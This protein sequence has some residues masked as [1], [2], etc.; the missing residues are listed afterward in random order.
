MNYTAAVAE[1]EAVLSSHQPKMVGFEMD[2]WKTELDAMATNVRSLFFLAEYKTF[3]H[4]AKRQFGKMHD[5]GVVNVDD[6][7]I[8][9]RCKA[10]TFCI[11][12]D[13]MH[14]GHL[15]NNTPFRYPPKDNNT[16]NTNRFRTQAYGR[17]Q[18]ASNVQGVRRCFLDEGTKE[19]GFVN[20]KG[21][22]HTSF[23]E[24]VISECL[25]E[26]HSLSSLAIGNVSA[27]KAHMLGTTILSEYIS[28]VLLKQ[29]RGCVMLLKG[30]FRAI[31]RTEVCTGVIYPNKVVSKPD[32]RLSISKEA[33]GAF[34]KSQ[35]YRVEGK[36]EGRKQNRNKSK[37]SSRDKEVN[38]AARDSNDT[39]VCC[40]ENTVEDCIMD[41]DASFHA[42]YCKEK[43]E[44]FKL[45]SGK[46]RLAVDKTLDIAG[47]GDVLKTSFD[48]SWTLKDV[49]LVVAR[50]N[51]RRS[52]YMVEVH[53]EGIGAIIDGSG[54]AALWF[55][56]AKESFPHN[57]KEDKET[58][59]VEARLAV[60]IMQT[61]RT[62]MLKMVP[63]TPL[64]FGVAK[65][66]S[67]TFR[68]E[69]MGLHSEAPKMLWADS[70]STT[71]LIYRIP[72][73]PIGLC[74]PEEEC[75]SDE[76]KY[77]FRDMKSHQ[78][79]QKSQVV[80]VD[81]PENLA[82][83]DSI[84]AEH[85]LSSKI[86][87]S[88]GGSSN[89]SEG[90]KNSRSFEDSGRLDEEYSKDGASSKEG[91]S[92]TPQIRISSR[93]SRAPVR[94]SPSA[95]YLLLTKNEPD[96][97]LSQITSKKEGITKIVDIQEPSYVGALNDTSTQHKSEG[98]QLAG[99]KE[100]LE[101]RLKEILYEL[102]QAL[103]LQYLKFN[104]FM[105]RIR[106]LIY[107]EDSW[108]EE[109]YRDVHQVG[110]EREVKVLRIFKWP[111]SELIMEDGVLPERGA[112][113][114][115]EVCTEV[116]TGVRY[117][118]I[119]DRFPP[120]PRNLL[121]V[122]TYE[123]DEDMIKELAE[124]YIDHIEREKRIQWKPR[125]DIMSS[126]EEGEETLDEFKRGPRGG[127]RPKVMTGRNINP[128]GYGKRQSFRVKAEI[129][130][131]VRNL[132]IEAVLD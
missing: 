15:L 130:N 57:V 74:I 40:V 72:Y 62:V 96:M 34:G 33:L 44:R 79:I 36:T 128:R 27:T 106:V 94:N 54:S 87:K 124:E 69:S 86:T 23:G 67:Q 52:L 38:Q 10:S 29:Q 50:G 73:V 65:R 21:F 99:Q 2:D 90:S 49:S 126:N 98:F 16:R 45:R 103:R 122:H 131:F 30:Q 64:Q 113:Y 76:M 24:P 84:V 109:P 60:G 125:K 9:P 4:I 46:V 59:E 61:F 56:E 28:W 63:E 48:T 75:G 92:E 110:N 71:Y 8:L 47:V 132:V 1:A 18:R 37:S 93:E 25:Q 81:I 78:P 104:S 6:E 31:Y 70:V 111:P 42:T 105:Q 95:N 116:C 66:L 39:L 3:L 80:L 100:N 12:R 53:P 88:L 118:N 83:N 101:C 91:G 77:S 97:F 55:G 7:V 17:Y 123:A 117:P 11:Q 5:K 82:E 43:L 20:I 13:G 121:N 114:R 115:T 119:K 127:D 129:P 108:N 107:V 51:K 58:V 19:F 89:T 22:S 102:I 41:S 14:S 68:A 26:H 32:R 85:G 120:F 112:I 35:T